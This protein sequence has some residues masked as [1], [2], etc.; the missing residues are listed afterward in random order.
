MLAHGRPRTDVAV[1]RD[2]FLTSAATYQAL[3]TDVPNYQLEPATG[4]VC[5]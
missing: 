3:A 1:Y 5:A 2:G 4:A